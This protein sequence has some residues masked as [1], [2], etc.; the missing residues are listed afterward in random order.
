MRALTK[1]QKDFLD[2]WLE[3]HKEE[4]RGNIVDDVMSMK[5]WKTLKKMNDTEIL[6]QNVERYLWDSFAII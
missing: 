1:R 2:K 3:E 6:Y 4:M 5:D